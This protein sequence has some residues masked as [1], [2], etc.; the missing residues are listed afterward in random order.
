MKRIKNL[1]LAGTLGLVGCAG[2]VHSG[3]Q[4]GALVG[5]LAS[6]SFHIEALTSDGWAIVSD[7]KAKT[8]SAV[9]I[10]TGATQLVLSTPVISAGSVG[11]TAYLWHDAV[12]TTAYAQLT[13]WSVA[14]G[15]KLLSANAWNGGNFWQGVS[16]DGQH[17][18]YWN[19]VDAAT[20]A[21][22][23]D[24]P[25]HTAPQVL[26]KASN[27][28]FRFAKYVSVGAARVVAGYCTVPPAGGASDKL[29]VS[30]NLS[31]GTS[32]TLGTNV[33]PGVGV[34][35][36]GTR[37]LVRSFD[38][39]GSLVALDGSSR[40]TVDASVQ[41]A[42]FFGDGVEMAFTSS[43]GKLKR[44]CTSGVPEVMQIGVA[45]L[46]WMSYDSSAIAYYTTQDPNSGN[47]DV[48]IAST[49]VAGSSLIV[50]ADGSAQFTGFTVDN[51]QALFYNAVDGAGHVGTFTAMPL[52]GGPGR[53]PGT[54][55]SAVWSDWQ[56][57]GGRTLFSD[58]YAPA[59][60][61]TPERISIELVDLSTTAPAKALAPNAD[62]AFMV[63]TD[64]S[65]LVYTT[66]DPTTGGLYTVAIP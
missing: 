6:G 66:S 26:V 33:R 53:V 39:S 58:Q 16:R 46:Y 24:N 29:A 55:Q 18:A 51:K 3:E 45:G 56:L 62:L 48:R 59:T 32:V 20:D 28:C 49:A 27:V 31:N 37:A 11:T 10:A 65:T 50:N 19:G 41:Q 4:N 54:G 1:I 22:T 43:D 47:G 35:P 13:A 63:S 5:K 61:T 40:A 60:A 2:G 64:L 23:V 30:Y 42:L 14:S 57:T 52:A 36:S 7:K 8:V 9:N 44:I 34:D 38:G 12:G 25:A 21:L 17:I 15:A